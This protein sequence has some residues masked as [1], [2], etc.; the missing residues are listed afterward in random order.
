PPQYLYQI[1]QFPASLHQTD[2]RQHVSVQQIHPYTLR[3]PTCLTHQPPPRR[4]RTISHLL[5]VELLVQQKQRLP[6]PP[7]E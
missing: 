1:Q 7:H 5:S 6:S 3:K 4:H 2:P